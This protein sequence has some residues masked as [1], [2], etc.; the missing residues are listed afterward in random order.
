MTLHPLSVS[1][2]VSATFV[3]CKHPFQGQFTVSKSEVGI[4]DKMILYISLP[5]VKVFPKAIPQVSC[6]F[7]S[8]KRD[9]SYVAGVVVR[10]IPVLSKLGF[11]LKYSFKNGYPHDCHLIKN[12]NG[13]F[14]ITELS[15]PQVVIPTTDKACPR[16]WSCAGGTCYFLS[17]SAGSWEQGKDFCSVMGGTLAII[18]S[19]FQQ[20]FLKSKLV[21]NTWI[22]Y[23]Q[24]GK[25]LY[26]WPDNTTRNYTSWAHGEP[27][28]SKQPW[29]LGKSEE[30]V[31]MDQKRQFDWNDERCELKRRFVCSIPVEEAFRNTRSCHFGWEGFGKSCYYFSPD[32]LRWD[33]SQVQCEIMGSNLTTIEDEEEHKFLAGFLEESHWIGLN[34]IINESKFAWQSGSHSSFRR[35]GNEQPSMSG[36]VLGLKGSEDCVEMKKEFN[37]AWNDEVCTYKDQYVCLC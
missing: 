22:G 2:L 37:Y 4:N 19:S 3:V 13:T 15:P 23:K 11:M 8:K 34:K 24:I 1:L 20:K 14:N 9:E 10:K 18:S 36:G 31:E 30:C 29:I 12:T 28:G 16:G 5:D 6:E 25:S 7:L 17:N 26:I 27:S 32:K 35:W 33:D 21:D